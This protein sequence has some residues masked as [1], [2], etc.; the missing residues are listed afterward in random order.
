MNNINNTNLI[1]F[2][3]DYFLSI[4]IEEDTINTF[5]A[6]NQFDRGIVFNLSPVCL[7]P[8]NK[9]S[10]SNSNQTHIH[11]TGVSRYFFFEKSEADSKTSSA[12]DVKI[13]TDISGA[14]LKA[15]SGDVDTIDSTSLDI[16]D[17]FTV[18]KIAHRQNQEN[19]VQIS[20]IRLDDQLFIELRSALYANDL[21][22]FLGYKNSKRLF[23]VGIPKSYYS[24]IAPIGNTVFFNLNYK[25]NIKIKSALKKIESTYDG[26]EVITDIELINDSI[27]QQQLTDAEPSSTIYEPLPKSEKTTSSVERSKRSAARGKEAVRD[28]GYLCGIDNTHTTFISRTGL[29]Y[30][31]AHHLIPMSKQDDFKNSLDVKANIIPLCPNCHA[32]IHYGSKEEV[33]IFI[34]QLYN[35]RKDKLILSGINIDLETL[36]NYYF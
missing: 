15:L 34:E 12:A 33:C 16:K 19:Q 6:K 13:I 23:A 7:M 36:I 10:T 1:E 4:G 29:P 35:E 14:N 9:P 11:V 30:I 26:N 25:L 2:V 18:S 3:R 28:G 5:F 17:S 22:I 21:L 32:K 31:E 24:T 8:K 20:K 27:Y